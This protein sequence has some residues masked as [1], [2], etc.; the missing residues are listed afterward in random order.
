MEI[1]ELISVIVPVYNVEMYLRRCLDSIISSTYE[2]LE[3]ICINDGSTDDSL[4]ILKEY[5]LCDGRIVIID[6]PNGGI[7]SARNAG[8]RISK[9]DYIAFIDS[10]D[11]IHRDYFRHLHKAIKD[12]N[13]D[14]AICDY[15]RTSDELALEKKMEYTYRMM[16]IEEMSSHHDTKSYVWKRL[17]KKD[18][19]KDIWFD[20]TE[21]VEDCIYNLDVIVKNSSLRIAYVDLKLYAYYIREGS[22]VTMIDD[23]AVLNLAEKFLKYSMEEKRPK[24]ASII[25]E[26]AIKRSLSTRYSAIIL[27]QKSNIRKANRIIKQSLPYITNNRFKYIV[28][29]YFPSIY[30]AYRIYNDKSMLIYEKQLR[31]NREKLI[32]E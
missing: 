1:N 10:D 26:D 19:V 27:Q 25:A 4:S 16:S 5:E 3:I 2:N 18:I 32:N 7:S 17:F 31:K 14:I 15:I 9:G 20:E 22:L 28:L 24:I 23:K 11:W 30:R 8:I 29:L 21:K 12:T 13:A 6:K